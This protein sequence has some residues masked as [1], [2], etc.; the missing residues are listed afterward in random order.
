MNFRLTRCIAPACVDAE[1]RAGGYRASGRTCRI[2]LSHRSRWHM[3]HFC[4]LLARVDGCGAGHRDLLILLG[5]G[6]AT[7]TDRADDLACGNNG[8]TAL[9]RCKPGNGRHIDHRRP[10]LVD[11]FFDSASRTLKH[12]RGARFSDGDVASGREGPVE[13]FDIDR[14]ATGIHYSDG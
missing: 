5:T 1:S 9:Q 6:C 10:T 13:A 8:Y 14:M 3:I 7:D 11:A 2:R 4:G 12:N